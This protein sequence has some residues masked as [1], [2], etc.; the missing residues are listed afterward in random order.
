MSGWF[1]VALVVAGVLLAPVSMVFGGAYWVPV[2][3]LVTIGAV[4]CVVVGREKW[5]GGS[6]DEPAGRGSGIVDDLDGQ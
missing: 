3:L 6:F 4:L 1:G 5:S 2:A